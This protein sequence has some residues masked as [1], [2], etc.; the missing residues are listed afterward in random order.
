MQKHLSSRQLKEESAHARERQRQKRSIISNNQCQFDCL[1]LSELGQ[2][3]LSKIYFQSFRNYYT[4]SSPFK[5]MH[6]HILFSKLYGKAYIIFLSIFSF[7]LTASCTYSK[8]ADLS[9][10]PKRI[11]TFAQ[12]YRSCGFSFPQSFLNMLSQ[13]GRRESSLAMLSAC[14][15][16]FLNSEGQPIDR[17]APSRPS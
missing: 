6:W 11:I 17:P 5:M 16:C 9:L 13:I 12:R 4:E 8:Q 14:S 10:L 2:E 7:L 3:R 15:I 1:C